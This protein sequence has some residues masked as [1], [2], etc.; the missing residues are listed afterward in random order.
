M[1]ETIKFI[2]EL[3]QAIY[4]DDWTMETIQKALQDMTG[5]PDILRGGE[6][7]ETS[8]AASVLE[9]IKHPRAHLTEDEI[10]IALGLAPPRATPPL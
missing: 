5:I 3:N 7:R 2:D 10:L 1:S 6:A 4:G 8:T 9:S